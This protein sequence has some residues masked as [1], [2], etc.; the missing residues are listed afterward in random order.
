M[1]QDVSVESLALVLHHSRAKGTD[2]LVAVGIANHDGDGG[3]WPT[4]ATLARYANTTERS[5]QRALANLL[6]LGEIAIHRQAGGTSNL[7]AWERP[8]RYDVLVSCPATCDGTKNHR[9]RKLLRAPADLWTEGVTPTSPGDTHVTGGVTPTSP[10]G[11]TP[12][13]PKPS[14]QPTDEQGVASVTGPRA[15]GDT[16]PCAECSAPSLDV[17][18]A[19]QAKLLPADRHHYRAAR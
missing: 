6:A 9:P 2:K 12:T 16:P 15:S 8:N 4:V 5:V 13:S 17:C 18:A 14:T 1:G 3:A 19:R 10:E 11:V 7:H